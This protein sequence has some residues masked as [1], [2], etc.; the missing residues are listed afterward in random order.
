MRPRLVFLRQ[1]PIQT[2]YKLEHKYPFANSF[3]NLPNLSAMNLEAAQGIIVLMFAQ[4]VFPQGLMR[5]TYT[6][7]YTNVSDDI[8]DA[9]INYFAEEL[10]A[11]FNAAGADQ[12]QMGKRNVKYGAKSKYVQRAEE[13]LG[14]GYKRTGI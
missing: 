13:I 10:L 6:A 9:A 5:T 2:L 1:Y 11:F 3:G 14:N 4:V 7:G 8:K 12:V